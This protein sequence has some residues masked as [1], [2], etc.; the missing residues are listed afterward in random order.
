MR[1]AKWLRERGL[2]GEEA[3]L[4]NWLVERA[5]PGAVEFC[6]ERVRNADH[7]DNA[8]YDVESLLRLHPK[9][10][11]QG[12]LDACGDIVSL[13]CHSGHY[14]QRIE[15]LR[16]LVEAADLKTYPRSEVVKVVLEL[17]QNEPDPDVR[18]A[19]ID[20]VPW[21]AVGEVRL[22]LAGA[23]VHEA[24]RIREAAARAVNDLNR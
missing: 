4:R 24:S 12:A 19:A 11:S 17:A 1:E 22:V 7:E 18:V 13:R 16:L 15:A 14:Q 8:H 5:V 3:P 6:M 2:S 21:T 20:L 9:P 23:L 10:L